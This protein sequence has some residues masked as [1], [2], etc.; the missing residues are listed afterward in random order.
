MQ[1]RTSL[2]AIAVWA[3][4]SSACASPDRPW[5]AVGA[6]WAGMSKAEAK[7]AGAENCAYGKGAAESSDSIYCDIPAAKRSLKGLEVVQAR[8]EFKPPAFERVHRIYVYVQGKQPDIVAAMGPL[9]GE[10]GVSGRSFVWLRDTGHVIVMS[11]RQLIGSATLV[12][13]FDASLQ[14]RLRKAQEGDAAKARIL[15]TF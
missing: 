10:V 3:T 14:A 8:M 12:F 11:R 4:V 2:I 13:G 9:Y 6:F 15:N 5:A 7:A 1:T